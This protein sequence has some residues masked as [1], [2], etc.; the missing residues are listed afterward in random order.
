MPQR[1][2]YFRSSREDRII[3]RRCRRMTKFSLV[4]LLVA[5]GL[6]AIVPSASVPVSAAS[7]APS[8]W[9]SRLLSEA[10]AAWEKLQGS[11]RPMSGVDTWTRASD[12]TKPSKG[13]F[14]KEIRRFW[15][16]DGAAKI[17]ADSYDRK[18]KWLIRNVYCFNQD[19]AFT[20]RQVVPDGEYFLTSYGR[21]QPAYDHVKQWIFGHALYI[22]NPT[23][24]TKLLNSTNFQVIR[25]D[26]A[27]DNR[28]LVT[29]EF[30]LS[31]SSQFAR[32]DPSPRH[33]TIVLEPN[34][35]WREVSEEVT[36]EKIGFHVRLNYV[37]N[38]ALPGDPLKAI[39]QTIGPTGNLVETSLD[40]FSSLSHQPIASS[41]FLLSSI[42]IAAVPSQTR[43]WFWP[44]GF[45]SLALIAI[46]IIFLVI[47][48]R[49]QQPKSTG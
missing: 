21:D 46:A 49:V 25:A 11:T 43:G 23:S 30:K 38:N 29:I 48:W 4:E 6:I 1:N 3:K 12:I 26:Q 36:S 9:R 10:P 13:V 33:G 8:Y 7:D 16:T 31:P 5:I 41:V 2:I 15:L 39:T 24:A 22:L 47:Y 27:T 28:N 42:G 17:V 32:S 20:A 34:V 37:S 14:Q 18:G 19:Y 40:E 35:D 44:S 45:I